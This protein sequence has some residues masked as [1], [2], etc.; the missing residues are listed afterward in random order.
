MKKI[1]WYILLIIVSN[2]TLYGQFNLS[3]NNASCGTKGSINASIGFG[4]S[5]R[6]KLNSGE[7]QHSGAFTNLEP[8]SYT[9]HVIDLETN[10]SAS[11]DTVITGS[12]ILG[13]SISGGGD[14]TYCS[15]LP[16][17]PIIELQAIASGGTPPIAYNWNTC[18]PGCLR[19]SASG[20]YTA[21]ATSENGC[22][23]K[24]S[25][26]VAY[27][28]IICI[29]SSDPND[30]TGTAGYGDPQWMSIN[31]NLAYEV[32]FENDP[33][34]ATGPA[35]KVTLEVPL[36]DDIALNSF[37]IGS[38]GFANLTFEVPPNLTFYQ[39]RLD[40]VDPLGVLVDV[41]IG[42]DVA[43][44]KAFWIF[45][46]IDPATGLPPD[47][48][49]LGML[50]VND[51]LIH[52][53]EG[54]VD[55]GVKPSISTQTGDIIEAQASIVFDQNAPIGTNTWQ[56]TID[57]LPPVSN[58]NSLPA[59]T[60][61]PTF[62]VSWE[63][64]DDIGGSGIRDYSLYVSK[65]GGFF[66]PNQTGI[67]GNS[68][69]FT[70]ELGSTY[71]FYTRAM[72][73]TGNEEPQKYSGTT[74]IYITTPG[75]LWYA[76]TDNDGYGDSITYLSS[77]SQP[78]G[79]VAIQGDC[80]D[81][82]AAVNPFAV[83][84]CNTIDDDCD[85]L[86]DDADGSVTGQNNYY[87]DIDG[88]SYG[89]GSA[90][91][92]CTQP[93]GTSTNNTD[94]ND[95]N[96]SIHPNAQEI[97][98]SYVDDDCDGL[99][100]DADGSITGQNSY[101]A[102]SDGDGY[103]G[104]IIILA[105][106]QPAMTT[107]TSNDC[108]DMNPVAYPGATELCNSIDDNCDNIVDNVTIC[109]KPTGLVT[110][111]IGATTAT[112]SWTGLPCATSY[113]YRYRYEITPGTWSA[114]TAFSPV[115]INFYSLT[116]LLVNTKYQ[117]QIRAVCNTTQSKVSA[118]VIFNTCNYYVFYPDNDL[119][120]YGTS[121]NSITVECNIPP[122][123]YA[124]NTEDCDDMVPTVHPGANESCNMIDDNCNGQVDEN[125]CDTDG[126][127]YAANQ[128]DCNEN[129]NAIYPGAFEA[130][131]GIDDNCDNIVDNVIVC[132][133]PTGLNTSSIEATTVNISWNLLPCAVNYVYRIRGKING[134]WTVYGP[135]ISVSSPPVSLSGL[136]Q[137][138][139]YQWQVRAVCGLKLS[140]KATSSFTTT[141]TDLFRDHPT[142]PDSYHNEDSDYF[143]QV[144]LYPNPAEAEIWVD[145]TPMVGKE[146]ILYL[147]DAMGSVLAE[148][149]VPE[150]TIE[151]FGIDV[152]ELVTGTY[153]LRV[154]T[155]GRREIS[156][157]FVV[158]R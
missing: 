154:S 8:G 62:T 5:F 145:L 28:P 131:N 13:L 44:R 52:N 39:E 79:Y 55:F 40:L 113:L 68:L 50:P 76:D 23:G 97:C 67:T 73:N 132:P 144:K 60:S 127:G 30:I 59:Q 9:V 81:N 149:K 4:G 18:G 15:N 78:S 139:L 147:Y 134:S 117:W 31:D 158:I 133:T 83:E 47:Q 85:G 104:N 99:A 95:N 74:P 157:P 53:G 115:A 51:S 108:D 110:T 16:P 130:C 80:N 92:L 32:R 137:S 112:I 103:G 19:V 11:R 46:A 20:K 155:T 136:Q 88:D 41:N 10:C 66:L 65:D 100:D 89:A 72:D 48:S 17:S 114:F 37:R 34:F 84:I 69:S 86:S 156:L 93:D 64:D 143:N 54:F 87:T 91:L 123:G 116:N 45:Q 151:A 90:I 82:N 26:V 120:G 121:D 22:I 96:S 105:C 75:T 107:V 61:N 71:S 63:G 42:V 38:F 25:V 58:V 125:G 146:V 14:I 111:F 6:F 148:Y 153:F 135:W 29:I 98:N 36:E 1:I 2:I 43:N 49:T 7:Y 122:T 70:G 33:T 94:C 27:I 138:T 77:V 150:V 57:A 141:G 128:G 101:Y 102:D 35:R 12:S 118:L 152:S 3:V 140:D 109:P 126:D 24:A 124:N 21:I 142:D 56:N 129:N 119:D 106:L